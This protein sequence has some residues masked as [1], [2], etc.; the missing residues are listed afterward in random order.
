MRILVAV[1]TVLKFKVGL[2]RTQMTPAAFFDRFL[3]RRGVADMT[4]STGN[5]PVP[6]SGSFDVI[7]RL[8]VT[9]YAF[10]FRGRKIWIIRQDAGIN[11]KHRYPCDQE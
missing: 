4:A 9:V 6:A 10:I 8:A 5:C 2:P 1:E 3:D 7:Y 11:R